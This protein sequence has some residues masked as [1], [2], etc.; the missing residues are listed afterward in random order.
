MLSIPFPSPELESEPSHFAPQ[1]FRPLLRPVWWEEHPCGG[2]EQRAAPC[3]PY[4]PQIRPERLHLQEASVQEGEGE[5]QAHIQR[6]GFY[7]RCPRWTDAGPRHLQRTGEDST[8]RL[9]G[10]QDGY[11]NSALCLSLCC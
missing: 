3:G 9:P 2:Y 11:N 7:A 8:K 6:S 5:G 1:V 4:A 10:E